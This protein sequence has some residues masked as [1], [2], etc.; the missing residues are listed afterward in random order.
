MNKAKK[1]S[2]IIFSLVVILTGIASYFIVKIQDE[3]EYLKIIHIEDIDLSIIDDGTYLGEY[4]SF[5]VSVI[6]EVKIINHEIVEVEIIKHDSGKGEPAEVIVE[7]V[8]DSQSLDV[9]SIA[10]ATYSSRVILLAIE[11][12]LTNT[13]N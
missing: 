2:L 6:L 9:D 12:A 1:L 13:S 8:I 5:P 4:A 7:T 3:L 11:A 10:G